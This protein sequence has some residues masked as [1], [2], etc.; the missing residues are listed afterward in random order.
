MDLYS[1]ITHSFDAHYHCSDNSATSY[2]NYLNILIFSCG[3][4]VAETAE[5]HLNELHGKILASFNRRKEPFIQ[6]MAHY[7][8]IS[9][10]NNSI[11]KFI[12]LKNTKEVNGKWLWDRYLLVKR[13]LVNNLIPLWNQ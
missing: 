11:F 9:F 10:K 7:I 4:E 13:V 1:Y 6:K 12:D 3:E 5:S 8:N 2:K